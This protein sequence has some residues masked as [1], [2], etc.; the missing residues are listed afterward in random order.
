MWWTSLM[1][2]FWPFETTIRTWTRCATSWPLTPRRSTPSLTFRGVIDRIREWASNENM[3]PRAAFY[4][5]R[6]EPEPAIANGGLPKKA[7]AKRVSTAALMDES[8]GLGSSGPNFCSPQLQPILPP[9]VTPWQK[10]NQLDFCWPLPRC[11]G[12]QMRWEDLW[13]PSNGE[14]QL[15]CFHLLPDNVLEFPKPSPMAVPA[16]AMQEDEP[17]TTYD[18]P[19]DFMMQT[20]NPAK[21]SPD[22]TG[23]SSYN[24]WRGASGHWLFIVFFCYWHSW[25]TTPG[26]LNFRACRWIIHLLLTISAAAVQEDEPKCA[27]SEDRGGDPKKPTF[28]PQL[29]REEWGISNPAHAGVGALDVGL[30]SRRRSSRGRPHDEGTSC[31]GRDGHRTMRRGLGRMGPRLLAEPSSRSTGPSLP[32]SEQHRC[33]CSIGRSVD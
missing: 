8:R 24:W 11:R 10:S 27:S 23:S 31:F 25:F 5:A 3:G 21:L 22:S 26:A 12:C 15:P 7:A 32:G 20:L 17:Y 2:S 4:S 29:P 28:S 6:E 30:C 1:T 16:K 19:Q 18:Q 33:L 14:G 9:A 13:N